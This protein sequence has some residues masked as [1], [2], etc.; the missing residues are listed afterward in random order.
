MNLRSQKQLA[1]R[2]M[3]C[4]TTRVRVKT[5]KDVDEAITRED[6]RG[7]IKKGLI[8]K[9]QKKGQNKSQSRK[10]LSQ[11]KKGRKKGF[12][13]RKGKAGARNP[14]KKQWMRTIRAVRDSLKSLKEKGLIDSQV[15]RRMYL[16][17]KGGSFKSRRHLLLY[18]KDHELLKVSEKPTNKPA[19]EGSKLAGRRFVKGARPLTKKPKPSKPAKPRKKRAGKSKK[20][21]TK[22]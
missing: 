10:R 9:V 1:A 22:K 19:K 6:I 20:K 2:I 7:L 5:D 18:L 8:W 15:Y 13:S 11:K 3:K 16:M 14:R 4:G 12:G 21:V 17:A